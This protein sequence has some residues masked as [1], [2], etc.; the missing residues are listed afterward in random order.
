M[1]TN[2]HSKD[3]T[4]WRANARPPLAIFSWLVL[5]MTFHTIGCSLTGKPPTALARAELSM[6]A[7]VEARADK[8]APMDLQRAREKLERSKKAMAA[9]Q[10]EDA[11]RLAETAQVEAQLA[12][13]KADAEIT[14]LAADTLRQRSD[15]LRQEIERDVTHQSPAASKE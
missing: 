2:Y 3:D 12:E 9:G 13:A 8:F 11:R 15:A 4:M 6:R 14:Q 7:A 5:I 1:A 10:Y